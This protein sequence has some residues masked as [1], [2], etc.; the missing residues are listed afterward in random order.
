MNDSQTVFTVFFAIF[1]GLV[2]NVQPRWKAF[3]LP[4]VFNLHWPRRRAVLSVCL[5]NVLPLLFYGWTLYVLN[6]AHRVQANWTLV[7]FLGLILHAVVPAFAAF[8][9][10]RL[11]L[12]IVE[13][14]PK[15]FYAETQA[16][17][18]QQ[19]Q[20]LIPQGIAIEP[21]LD[22]LSIRPDARTAGKNL[23]WAIVYLIFALALPFL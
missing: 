7:D 1:W 3:Q 15:Y 14:R 17:L 21:S 13:I 4:L 12:G 8:G 5:F 2:A 10:Y 9:F 11:W 19:Y 6:Q 22:E 23:F 16:T 20:R 18:P